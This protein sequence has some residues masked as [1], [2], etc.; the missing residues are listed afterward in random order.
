[1]TNRVQ[2]IFDEPEDARRAMRELEVEGA[3]ADG[4]LRIR[5]RTERG[6]YAGVCLSLRGRHQLVNA[7][8]AVTLAESLA[9]EGFQILYLID[10]T[11]LAVKRKA[12]SECAEFKETARTGRLTARGH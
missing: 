5:L 3:C 2:A 10:M 8:V 12:V 11:I 1:M 9:D 6:V 4:R 7:A